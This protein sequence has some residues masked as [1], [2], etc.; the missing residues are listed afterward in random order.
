MVN[1]RHF[2]CNSPV[3]EGVALPAGIPDKDADLAIG[4]LAECATILVRDGGRV[5]TLFGHARF[6]DQQDR[7]SFS[8]SLRHQKLMLA[9][10]RGRDPRAFANKGL[11]KNKR[12]TGYAI[13]Q[14]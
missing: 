14:A 4:D 7:I 5:L 2:K 1:K 13:L 3:K 11:S 8:Q 6:I 12:A 9:Q 10:E